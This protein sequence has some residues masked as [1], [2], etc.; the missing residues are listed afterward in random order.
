MAKT[1]EAWQAERTKE[2]ADM[3]TTLVNQHMQKFEV[4]LSRDSS[5]VET[6]FRYRVVCVNRRLCFT[7]ASGL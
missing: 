3:K 2:L 1:L 5:E 6:R 4:C 7:G